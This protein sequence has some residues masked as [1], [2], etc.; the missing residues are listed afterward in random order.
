MVTNAAVTKRDYCTGCR[1]DIVCVVKDK[2]DPVADELLANFVVGSHM[3]S[4]P[5]K[6]IL[7]PSRES[8]T[9]Y[10]TLQE[11]LLVQRCDPA[12]LPAAFVTACIS[13]ATP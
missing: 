2:V 4:H 8:I 3:Q 11:C 6:V 10:R 12:V 9:N 13:L 1:F 7:L 5:D